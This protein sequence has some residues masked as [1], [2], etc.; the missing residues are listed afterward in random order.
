MSVLRAIP[1]PEG[2]NATYWGRLEAAVRT[3][4]RVDRYQAAPDDPVLSP[5]NRRACPVPRCRTLRAVKDPYCDRHTRRWIDTGSPPMAEFLDQ[6]PPVNVARVAGSMKCG[7]ETCDNPRASHGWCR[8]HTGE[9]RRRGQPEDFATSA[10]AVAKIAACRVPECPRPEITSLYGLCEC[11][12]QR[13]NAAGRP[14]LEAFALTADP[15]GLVEQ[16]FV[17]AGLPAGPK[18]ELQYALQHRRDAQGA[19]TV[20]GRL[21]PLVKGIIAHDPQCRSILDRSLDEWETLLGGTQGKPSGHAW[22]FFRWTY[23]ELSLLVD[24]DPFLPDRWNVR[25]V[26][27]GTMRSSFCIDWSEIPQP[28][29]REAAKRWGRVRMA[30]RTAKTTHRDSKGLIDFALFLHH[31]TSVTSS[32]DISRREIEAYVSH[33]NAH[34]SDQQRASRLGTVRLFL[35]NAREQELLD[36]Q[37]NATVRLNDFPRPKGAVPRFLSEPVMA[38]LEAPESLA[39]LP[40]WCHNFIRVL[41]GTGRRA[42]EACTLDFNSLVEGPDGEPYLRYF[43]GKESKEHMIPLDPP[44]AAAIRDQQAAV[45]RRWPGGSKWL[46]P[47][48]RCNPTAVYGLP[49]GTLRSLLARWAKQLDLREPLPPDAPPGA[50]APFIQ[51]TSHRFR[52][53]IATRMINEDVPECV[54]QRFLGHES[55]SMTRRYAA[56]HDKT[57]KQAFDKYRERVTSEGKVVVYKPDSPM[58]EGMRL[59]D[60]LKRARQT[61]ANG[62]CAR[63]LQTDCI[64][65]NFCYGC[66]QFA[67]DVTF[68]P[69]LR[70]QRDRARAI[71]DQCVEEGREKWAERNN[72]DIAAL[73]PIIATLED[74]PGATDFA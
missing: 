2:T 20:P 63:P 51:L 28:W 49:Y 71:R 31:H 58:T 66:S 14:P 55:P 26:K 10:A 65:P 23:A 33:L 56:M 30:T 59:N 8:L 38:V 21:A 13:W 32:G 62:Y 67:S 17:F 68:L 27:P 25:R 6:V 74:L 9:W 7:V 54:I 73:E 34:A 46:F 16:I 53:T 72:R 11:H 60:R 41:I 70:G 50:E 15:V 47:R 48:T 4:F 18:L 69:V 52:H 35:R 19:R 57:L 22:S 36:L 45:L 37:A 43:A 3:E 61:L 24:G 40:P 29:L 5:S 39:L 42:S 64:H 44:T 1:T 12:R